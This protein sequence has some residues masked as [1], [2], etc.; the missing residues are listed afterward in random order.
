M[1]DV[2][3]IAGDSEPVTPSSRWHGT[4]TWSSLLLAGLVLYEA[5]NQPAVAVATFCSKFGWADFRTAQWLYRYDP[6]KERGRACWWLYVAWG[7]WKIGVAAFLTNLALAIVAAA[8]V[9]LTVFFPAGF[10]ANR[11][12]GAPQVR[13]IQLMAGA[14]VTLLAG[15]GFS[16]CAT[17]WAVVIGV[18]NRIRL[19]LGASV[20]RARRERLWPPYGGSRKSEN[21]IGA[22]QLTGFLSLLLIVL[23]F[24]IFLFS[25]LPFNGGFRWLPAAIAIGIW[26]AA[27]LWTKACHAVTAA[28]AAECW[29]PDELA[30][31]SFDSLQ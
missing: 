11:P 18:R 19:W 31:E 26:P 23:P 16:S 8:I 30:A 9:F 20:R 28:S 4:V 29:P 22:L 2:E 15:L 1:A 13:L 5:T 10:V 25:R 14:G 24:C 17:L 7:L 6:R 27:W 3:H 12:A 21:R